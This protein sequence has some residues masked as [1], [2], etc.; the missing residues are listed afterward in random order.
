MDK[1]D[2]TE[3]TAYSWE[4]PNCGHYNCN[5]KYSELVCDGCNEKFE[6]GIISN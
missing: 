4:C 1:V 2:V 5:D 6:L 3:I